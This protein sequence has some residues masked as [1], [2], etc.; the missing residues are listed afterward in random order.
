M[1]RIAF[2][3]QA[4]DDISGFPRAVKTVFGYALFLAQNGGKHPKAIA[5]KGFP[6]A[7]VL[8]VRDD[9]A[10][11]TYRLVYTT[12]GGVAISVLHA[13]MKKSTRGIKTPK[14]IVDTIKDRLKMVK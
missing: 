8:E 13:F 10:G 6:G 11:N 7:S 4:K 9:H 2:I 3:A 14:T 1:K 12:K 5:M